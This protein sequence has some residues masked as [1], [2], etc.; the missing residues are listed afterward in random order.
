MD[1]TCTTGECLELC[2]S[3]SVSNTSSAWLQWQSKLPRGGKVQVCLLILEL[4]KEWAT[5]EKLVRKLEAGSH[6]RYWGQCQLH[7]AVSGNKKV[8]YY[9]SWELSC[10]TGDKGTS[11]TAPVWNMSSRNSTCSHNPLLPSILDCWLITAKSI[12][13]YKMVDQ[14]IMEEMNAIKA[15]GL[16]VWLN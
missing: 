5:A 8:K 7:C 16:C 12:I 13:L 15:L 11:N 3:S 2:L 14:L 4:C 9:L 1:I 10:T 6:Q